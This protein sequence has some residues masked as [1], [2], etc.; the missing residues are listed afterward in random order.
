MVKLATYFVLALVCLNLCG[1]EDSL[2]WGIIVLDEELTKKDDGYH[3]QGRLFSGRSLHR[4]RGVDQPYPGVSVISWK[5]GKMHGPV[6]VYYDDERKH[7]LAREYY[8][9]GLREGRSIRWFRNGRVQTVG[10]YRRGLQDGLEI[11]YYADGT[12]ASEISY[13]D[14]K[15]H[16]DAKLWDKNGK[17]VYH[18]IYHLGD[19]MMATKEMD[20]N[21]NPKTSLIEEA[22]AEHQFEA[23]P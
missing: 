20:P 11:S 1:A 16:G 14:G 4:D 5:R 17:L 9:Y 6:I 22:P 2:E 3:Y 13:I 15:Q 21:F 23:V 7:Q 8:E 10:S 19:P 12:K 18:I